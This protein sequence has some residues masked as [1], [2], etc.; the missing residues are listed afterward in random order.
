MQIA[1]SIPHLK[2]INLEMLQIQKYLRA[3]TM[4][5]VENSIPDL[6]YWV[7]VKTQVHEKY[8]INYL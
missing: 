3:D 5:P 7:S 4:S 1:L 6:M 2:N 8:Y